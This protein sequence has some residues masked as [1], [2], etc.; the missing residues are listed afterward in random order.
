MRDVLSYL[1][2][3]VVLLLLARPAFPAQAGQEDLLELPPTP[4]DAVERQVQRELDAAE[5]R[6]DVILG[7]V[8]ERSTAADVTVD[9]AGA[10]ALSL[11][12]NPALAAVEEQRGELAAGVR[13]AKADAFPQLAAIA[14]YSRSRNPSFL[15]SPDFEDILAQFPEGDFVPSEQILYSTAVELSQPIYTFGKIGSAIELARVLVDAVEAQIGA[16]RLDTALDAAEAYYEVLSAREELAVGLAQRR[17]RR[18]ALEVVRARYE[19]G[20]ATRLELLRA[21]SALAE[22]TPEIARLAGDLS[23]ARSRLGNVLGVEPGAA[24]EVTGG[25]EET[26]PPVPALPELSAAARANR[27]EI[28]DLELQRQA[29]ATQQQVIRSEALPQV[30]LVGFYGREA[31]IFDNLGEALFDNY[32]LALGVRWEL[33][34]GGRRKGRIAR[35]ESQR[36]QLAY[37]L[38][39]LLSLIRLDLEQSLAA[40]RT[41]QERWRAAQTAATAA[42]E[43]SRVARESYREG[44]A[45]Q[46]DWLDAQRQETEAEILAVE[47]YYEARTEA[48]RLARAVGA[49]PTEGWTAAED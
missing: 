33:F 41:A 22:V 40:Y 29:L 25:V 44:V 9:L 49:Y 8:L 31:R 46:T 23:V 12:Q 47:T 3:V 19:I 13:E 45:L 11:R 7:D 48:A 37:Q 4:E 24:L 27:P 21:Q 28:A 42:R 18:E 43:A 2:S 32:S 30:D 14:S 6:F 34:D 36:E 16:A 15:N 10:V 26:L 35:L 20:E 5:E 17:V 39:D 1:L 38:D